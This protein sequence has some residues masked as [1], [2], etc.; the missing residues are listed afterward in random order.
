M[1]LLDRPDRE[2]RALARFVARCFP[3]RVYRR[4]AD[5][6]GGRGYLAMEL[7]RRGYRVTIID[8]VACGA[9]PLRWAPTPARDWHGRRVSPERRQRL[10][11]PHARWHVAHV[12]RARA[13]R[14]RLHA[15]GV[16]LWRRRFAPE[17][18]YSYDLV[19]AQRAHGATI[20]VAAAARRVPVVLLPCSRCCLK[21]DRHID[22]WATWR[23]AGIP[24]RRTR[25]PNAQRCIL[26]TAGSA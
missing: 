6:A 21:G 24:A 12:Q 20:A 13:W 2:D 14:A 5:V 8:P 22:V 23:R 19:V 26:W 17:L 7:A 18:A 16:K 10:D 9:A 3:A 1:K 15:L 25:I 4:V 11:A